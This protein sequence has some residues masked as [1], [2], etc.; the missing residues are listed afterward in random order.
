MQIRKGRLVLKVDLRAWRRDLLDKGLSEVPVDGAIGSQAAL[1]SDLQGDP[2]DRI[3]VATALL[4]GHQLITADRLI[5][6]WPGA[7]NRLDATK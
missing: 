5:L 2:A 6:G 4:G 7:I 3:I 1:L